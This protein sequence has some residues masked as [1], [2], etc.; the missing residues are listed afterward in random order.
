MTPQT[1]AKIL[2]VL[3][4]QEFEPV[5]GTKTVKVDIRVIAATNKSLEEKMREGTFREDLYYRLNVVQ[6]EIPPLNE[7]RE[8]IPLLT[9]FF[10]KKY[11]KKN[12]KLIKSIDPV[13]L[14]FL[15]RFDWPGNVRELENVIERAVILTRGD[16]ISLSDFPAT[17]NLKSDNQERPA[18]I[19]EYGQ[20]LKDV[21]RQMII[22]T[23]DANGGNRTRTSEILGISRRTLQLKL[24]E[25][26][27]N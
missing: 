24:K 22:K 23:L 4:E 25:Y 14:D 18:P 19:L 17:I 27:I 5:G 20:T 6:V 11:S 3:Q 16:S 26:G 8:D 10:I 1:Q 12:H 2:R 9:D 15:M 21:E 13:A 7:R